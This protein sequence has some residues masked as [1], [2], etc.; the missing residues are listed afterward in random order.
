MPYTVCI[1]ELMNRHRHVRGARLR[2][3][4]ACPSGAFGGSTP[5][6]SLPH[7]QS[8]RTPGFALRAR[9]GLAFRQGAQPARASERKTVLSRLSFAKLNRL[10]Q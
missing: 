2:P 7:R 8:R 1:W 5:A 10:R 4:R 9:S 3:F 6:A